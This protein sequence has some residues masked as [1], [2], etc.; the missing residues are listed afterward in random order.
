[1]KNPFKIATLILGLSALPATLSAQSHDVSRVFAQLTELEAERLSKPP[2]SE[3]SPRNRAEFKGHIDF[4]VPG[5]DELFRSKQS[6]ELE[7]ARL[8]YTNAL[9]SLVAPPQPDKSSRAIQLLNSYSDLTAGSLKR[10]LAGVG[11]SES[12][13]DPK[14]RALVKTQYLAAHVLRLEKNLAEL[15]KDVSE[16]NDQPLSKILM[17]VLKAELFLARKLLNGDYFNK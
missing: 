13:Q 17:A 9:F 3:F 14:G 6:P 11:A 4:T 16:K 8:L 1:M 5:E 10:A 7:R 15:G 12:V 2:A